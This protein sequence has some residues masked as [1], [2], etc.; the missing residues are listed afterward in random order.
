MGICL[1]G[2]IKFKA[3]RDT[4]KKTAFTP[5]WHDSVVFFSLWF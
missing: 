5:K 2:N 3:K 4:R 1:G